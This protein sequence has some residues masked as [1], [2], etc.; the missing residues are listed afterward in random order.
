MDCETISTLFSSTVDD[1]LEVDQASF[2]TYAAKDKDPTLNYVGAGYYQC[3]C[4]SF[5]TAAD[6]ISHATRS[7]DDT[8]AETEPET[9]EEIDA[10]LKSD[11]SSLCYE[12]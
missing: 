4:T 9:Q 6:V 5:S 12:F 11:T 10:A 1:E 7:K 3:Y 8:V 2:Y